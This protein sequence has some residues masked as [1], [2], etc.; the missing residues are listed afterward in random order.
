[1]EGYK[2]WSAYKAERFQ[3][4]EIDE[5]RM[6]IRPTAELPKLN[7]DKLTTLFKSKTWTEEEEK[8]FEE[9]S[10]KYG[11][12]FLDET[13]QVNKINFTSYLRSGNSLARKYF[14]DITCIITGSNMDNRFSRNFALT[15]CGF[16]GEV[17]WDDSVWIYKSHV[18]NVQGNFTRQ[19]L[20]K[21]IICVRNP[22]DVACSAVQ[23]RL[24][25]THTLSSKNNIA[26]DFPEFW[27]EYLNQT[28]MLYNNFL[29]Y[30][31]KFADS[32]Q[33]PVYFFR[34]EDLIS[35]PY[36][37]LREIF[38]FMLGMD[39]MEGTFIE[40][41]IRNRLE[42]TK[43]SKAIYTPRSGGVIKSMHQFTDKQIDMVLK[44]SSHYINYFGYANLLSNLT[45]D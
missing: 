2:V 6:I 20:N 41:R 31:T 16:K 36:N 3:G 30:W 26:K 28:M 38:E 25:Y 1:M 40:K 14:E 32:K 7:Y 29:D 23:L 34:Y 11:C 33:V 12:L 45:D 44:G 15:L 21:A 42:N 22:F 24:T 18:P 10:S 5:E 9:L 37:V 13:A 17:I 35:D 4:Y 8:E 27:N 39:S 43:P 19:Y